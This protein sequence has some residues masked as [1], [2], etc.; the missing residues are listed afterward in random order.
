MRYT[1]ATLAL[2]SAAQA[3]VPAAAQVP[4]A[5]PILPDA[6]V[7]DVVA[8][9]EVTRV[10]DVATVRAGVVTQ[11]PTA[12]A[13]LSENAARME[14]VVAALRAAGIASRDIAT[15]SVG[16]SP[17]YRYADNQPPVITGY[18]ANNTVSIKFRDIARSGAALDALVKAGANQIDGPQ[19]SIDQPEAALDEARTNAIARA[20]ARAELYARAAGM[21]VD[22]IAAIEENGENAGGGPRPPVLYVQSAKREAATDLMP[23]ETPVSVTVAVR[24]LL[25]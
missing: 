20:R 11:A 19:L 21:R 10:P 23:G 2:V 13:A 22:R 4:A 5:T 15:A 24:F 1:I 18:Q 8:T 17:Q 25:K 16:L 12:A 14:K 3:A 7:L 6:T 9:G